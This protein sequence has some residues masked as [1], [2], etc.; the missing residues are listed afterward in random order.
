M[1]CLLFARIIR[2]FVTLTHTHTHTQS[3]QDSLLQVPELQ[4]AGAGLETQNT[5][6]RL[7]ESLPPAS[8]ELDSDIPKVTRPPNYT[9]RPGLILT[10]P[11]CPSS[12]DCQGH[13]RESDQEYLSGLKGETR[14]SGVGQVPP[15]LPT[16]F[17]GEAGRG[18]RSLFPG[19][20]P[21]PPHPHPHGGQDAGFQEGSRAKLG[22]RQ[23]A[24]IPLCPR[25][26]GNLC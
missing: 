24:G 19:P 5:S 9:E 2:V 23:W 17:P 20:P 12:G 11:D 1:K 15:A 4:E 10:A 18:G 13:S 21:P 14:E 7:W 6:W 8:A 25:G 26:V 16:G 22:G 3:Q